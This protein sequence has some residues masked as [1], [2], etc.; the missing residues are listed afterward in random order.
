MRTILRFA[1]L[2]SVLALPGCSSKSAASVAP[3]KPPGL[4][5]MATDPR[6]EPSGRVHLSPEGLAFAWPNTGVALRFRGQSLHAQ[7]TDTPREDELRETDWLSVII[8]DQKPARLQLRE[9]KSE[10]VLADKL[11]PG[12]HTV[13][14]HKRT[15]AEVGTVTLH[16][17]ALPTGSEITP[18]P[19]RPERRIDV[20]G[21]SVSAGY[22]NEGP[23]AA[24]RWSAETEDA[25]RAYPALAAQ[26]LDA[27]VSVMAWSGKGVTRNYDGKSESP[28]PALFE[29]V[30]PADSASP[31]ASI[32]P[33]PHVVVVNLGTN[34]FVPGIPAQQP[35]TEAYV[36]LLGRVH[37]RAPAVPL[38]LL[39]PPTLADDHPHP[40]ARATIKSYL[41]KIVADERARGHTVL[42]LEQFVDPL[43]G[44]GCDSHPNVKTHA[45]L[46][47]ELAEAIRELTG[48]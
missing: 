31:T 11:D 4:T 3:P 8:D 16:H 38:V 39:V 44:L 35:F 47:S 6:I 33:L 41:E 34:D 25:T 19:R 18:A 13:R 48:W 28:M 23:H 37:E 1:M 43:E 45:R 22:G 2:S 40:K 5:V 42:L 21:D 7:L 36:R 20:I 27:Q 17:F 15:E 10:Y 9:G 46:A 29:L 32:A 12:E 14:I 26:K 24:C 30:L